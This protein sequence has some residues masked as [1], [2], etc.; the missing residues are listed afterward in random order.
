MSQ[1]PLDTLTASARLVHLDLEEHAEATR[2]VEAITESIGGG[3]SQ[4]EVFD[5]LRELQAATRAAETFG[6]WSIVC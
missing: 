3:L 5:A 1:V 6:G 4:G 2:P